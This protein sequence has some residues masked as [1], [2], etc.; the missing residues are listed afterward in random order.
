MPSLMGYSRPQ[1]VHTSAPSTTCRSKMMS[2]SAFRNASS[3]SWASVGG[4]LGIV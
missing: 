3:A 4:S 2:W 1:F